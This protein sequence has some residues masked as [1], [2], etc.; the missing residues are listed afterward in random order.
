MPEA[1]SIL[2]PSGASRWLYCTRSIH[3][4]QQH[5][6]PSTTS[7]AA[8]EGR[9]AHTILEAGAIEALIHRGHWFGKERLHQMTQEVDK[10][11]QQDK[12]RWDVD[13]MRDDAFLAIN[14]MIELVRKDPDAQVWVE[15]RVV[16]SNIN[17]HVW[18][19][20]DLIV[21][22]PNLDSLY[23]IDYKYG[24]VEV[25]AEENP[26][27]LLYLMASLMTL[28]KRATQFPK[29]MVTTI[30]QP[31]SVEP[32][33]E[34]TVSPRYISQVFY[35]RLVQAL[36]EIYGKAEPQYHIAESSCKYC[37][38]IHLCPEMKKMAEEACA[39]QDIGEIPDYADVLPKLPLLRK[40]ADAI[41]SK[42]LEFLIDGGE[43][44]GY[45]LAPRIGNRQW[46]SEAMV[47]E[48]MK[49]KGFALKDIAPPKILSPAQM[50]KL[51][52]NSTKKLAPEELAGYSSR[53]DLGQK[54][55]KTKTR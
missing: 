11:E 47:L 10:V 35:P 26:Q 54:L 25:D 44:N 32:I 36:D 51:V 50:D 43:I 3:L 39:F 19:T 22:L 18:G 9:A 1:H 31:K 6:P 15:E 28:L 52:K 49:K 37:P 40:W 48:F 46:A 4:I 8:L 13:K 24:R 55:A 33:K 42:A 27:L 21:W 7:E 45:E 53:P 16:L 17:V 30:V 20:A 12:E 5:K 2:G 23:V 29:K 41:E 34:W 14:Y 38:V